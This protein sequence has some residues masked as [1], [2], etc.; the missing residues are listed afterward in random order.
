MRL[1]PG[2]LTHR[3]W[4]MDFI[5]ADGESVNSPFKFTLGFQNVSWPGVT[6]MKITSLENSF[7]IKTKDIHPGEEKFVMLEHRVVRLKRVGTQDLYFILPSFPLQNT[8]RTVPP[9]L[10]LVSYDQLAQHIGWVSRVLSRSQKQSV[11]SLP[12]TPSHPPGTRTGFL[13]QWLVIDLAIN[14]HF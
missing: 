4:C 1:W 13:G 6:G 5:D 2:A 10:Q 9:T 3:Q 14:Q 8:A 11:S 7:G 12:S